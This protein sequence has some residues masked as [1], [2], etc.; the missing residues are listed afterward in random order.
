MSGRDFVVLV[1]LI[2]K[3]QSTTLI[4]LKDRSSTVSNGEDLDRVLEL[5]SFL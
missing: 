3:G 1:D 2:N 4:R 5:C